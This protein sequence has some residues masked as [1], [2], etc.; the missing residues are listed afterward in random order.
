M[1]VIFSCSRGSAHPSAQSQRL[2]VTVPYMYGNAV[3]G[4]NDS[5]TSDLGAVTQFV[6]N[7]GGVGNN[8]TGK[9]TK[10]S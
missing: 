7:N 8:N 9:T 10:I 1:L 4:W 2:P 3:F 5:R 6:L